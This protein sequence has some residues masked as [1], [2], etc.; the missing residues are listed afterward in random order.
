MNLR[1]SLTIAVFVHRHIISV[2]YSVY[3]LLGDPNSR[4][5]V[6]MPSK[7]GY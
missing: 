2:L 1:D 3:D 7:K 4:V 6:S 5:M